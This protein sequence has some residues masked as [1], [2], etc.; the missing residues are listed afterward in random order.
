M[1]MWAPPRVSRQ[2]IDARFLPTKKTGQN[3]I[4]GVFSPAESIPDPCGAAIRRC[5]ARYIYFFFLRE[6]YFIVV[7]GHGNGVVGQKKT[8]RKTGMARSPRAHVASRAQKKGTHVKGK[9]KE[10]S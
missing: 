3:D 8:K 5:G 6:M 10:A 7:A 4:V 1:P 2:A 9:K